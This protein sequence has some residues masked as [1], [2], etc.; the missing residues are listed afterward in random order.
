MPNFCAQCG[1]P[2]GEDTAFCTSCG[3]KLK[4]QDGTDQAAASSG[5][6]P[7]AHPVAAAVRVPARKGKANLAFAALGV[8]VLLGGL[9]AAVIYTGYRTASRAQ[10]PGQ[11]LGWASVIKD[12]PKSAGEDREALWSTSSQPDA[13][14]LISKEEVAAATGTAIAEATPN[15]DKDA[16]TFE[17]RDDSAVTVVVDVKWHNGN[18][19]M[20][21]LPAMSEQLVQ[22]D[23]RH[24]VKGIGDEAYVLGVDENTQKSLNQVAQQLKGLSSFATGPLTFRKGDVWA[25]VTV[26][27]AENKVEVEKRIA[28]IVAQ[29]I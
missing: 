17:S 24:P 27:A 28:L 22:E 7:A 8:T 5:A 26:T 25:N 2:F 1:T 10:Q 29:R 3:T 20:R 6:P 21:A 13:C 9:A 23:I 15:E 4:N 12:A 14:S 16:C 19:A 11:D 18:L